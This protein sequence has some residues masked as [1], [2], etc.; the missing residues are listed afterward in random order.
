MNTSATKRS[1]AIHI[2]IEYKEMNM[3]GGGSGAIWIHNACANLATHN[4]LCDSH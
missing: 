4:I 3:D 2:F 1:I